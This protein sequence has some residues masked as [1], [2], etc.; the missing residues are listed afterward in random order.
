MKL[1]LLGIII[2]IFL[3]LGF[4]AYNSLDRSIGSL[5]VVNSPAAG[6]YSVASLPEDFISDFD[7]YNDVRPR[8]RQADDGDVVSAPVLRKKRQQHMSG[9]VFTNTVIK[10]PATKFSPEML[11][12][13]AMQKRIESENAKPLPPTR[14]VGHA[15]VVAVRADRQSG[16]RS[17]FS[18]S[19]SVI[20]KPYDWVKAL[21]SKLQ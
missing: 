12:L 9:A 13:I 5:Y 10:I 20:K 11:H 7:R 21:G 17:F 1:P 4:T 6:T 2:I 3:Q 14:P 19:A 8:L 15:E 18:R 16:K